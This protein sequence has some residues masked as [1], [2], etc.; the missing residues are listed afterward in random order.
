MQ[1][2]LKLAILGV[3]MLVLGLNSTKVEAKELGL[4]KVHC[5]ASSFVY[6]SPDINSRRLGDTKT[7]S[8]Y[9]V[10]KWVQGTDGVSDYYCIKQNGKYM[11]VNTLT[12]DRTDTYTNGLIDANKVPTVGFVTLEGNIRKGAYED[13]INYYC[14]LPSEI[15]ELFQIEGHRIKMTEQYIEEEAYAGYAPWTGGYLNAVSDY[16]KKMVYINDENGRYIVHEMGHYVNNKLGNFVNRPEN[17]DLYYSEAAKVSIYS[18][19]NREYFCEAFDQ[20][21]RC[22]DLLKQTSPAS[23]DL[24]DRAVTEFKV[25]ATPILNEALGRG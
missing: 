18:D 16:E 8:T 21:F 22:P 3:G 1:S 17:R 9:T 10:Y 15:R 20:Y 12:Y 7:G 24:V 4:F 2:R 6:E 5:D 23:Y 14:L 25:I 19:N 13:M 11:W